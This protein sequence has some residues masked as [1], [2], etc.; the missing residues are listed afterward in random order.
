MPRLSPTLILI[1]ILAAIAAVAAIA[2]TILETGLVL[3][4]TSTI[5]A[6][7]LAL[8]A[9]AEI[10]GLIDRVLGHSSTVSAPRAS[11]TNNL[12]NC[13]DNPLD[14]G[15]QTLSVSAAL[16]MYF[17]SLL[18]RPNSYVRFQGQ[19]SLH[20]SADPL[21]T[22]DEI[23]NQLLVPDGK[24]LLILA[25][26]G[27]MGKSTI[28]AQ[29]IRC[30]HE[31]K[32]IKAIYGD[33]AKAEYYDFSKSQFVNI[34]QPFTDPPT[35]LNLLRQQTGLPPVS[36]QNLKLN[37]RELRDHILDTRAIILVDNLD[38]VDLR[39]ELVSFLRQLISPE[40]RV[41]VTTREV[42]AL[43]V[44]NRNLMIAHLN[45]LTEVRI[46]S[47]FLSWHVEKHLV[48]SPHLSRL[49]PDLH[50][51]KLVNKLI[52][53]T[54]GIPLIMQIVANEIAVFSWD[55]LDELPENLF[56]HE[57]LAYLYDSA[58]HDLDRQGNSG[59]LA[60][61]ILRFVA[62]YSYE[63]TRITSATLIDQ[64]TDSSYEGDLQDALR[65]LYERFLIINND[66]KK[67][68]FSITP[69]LAGYVVSK[70]KHGDSN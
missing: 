51:D 26:Q 40:L 30:L 32:A 9:V 66:M 12:Q 29:I 28:A 36:T 46:A 17:V 16:G 60:K 20:P 50:N 48:Q 18:E 8:A 38:T 41:I 43:D 57:L 42:Q 19:L 21:N 37:I 4:V 61:Q 3:T 49:L 47:D 68:D 23:I 11:L 25:S 39:A 62:R 58:W 27:G 6:V 44:D 52:E 64:F 10:V 24:H 5:L 1:I 13:G 2:T 14:L 45:P 70:L 53:R 31:R 67:G 34:D 63:G 22:F 35:F 15:N 33:S 55:R 7:I 65:H 69:S 56:G 59:Q 54:G